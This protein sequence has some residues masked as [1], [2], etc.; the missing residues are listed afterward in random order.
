MSPVGAVGDSRRRVGGTSARRPGW[1]TS[2]TKRRMVWPTPWAWMT[3]SEHRRFRAGQHRLD[4]RVMWAL[5]YLGQAL[6]VERPRRG[7]YRITERGRSLLHDLP[8][9]ITVGDLRRY[10]E[11]V[12]FEGRSA[13]ARG[14]GRGDS[15]DDA[16]TPLEQIETAIASM[17]AAVAA[18]PGPACT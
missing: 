7:V 8:D 11:F 9:T 10:P 16:E 5:S 13:R 4:N 6:A 2:Y 3:S 12:E 15:A 1:D 17:D 14:Q 18:R